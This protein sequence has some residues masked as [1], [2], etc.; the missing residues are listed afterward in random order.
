VN[1][2]LD[3]RQLRAFTV[4][5]RVASFTL[6]AK[7]LFLSQSAVSHSMKAL[8]QEVGC[9]LFD[10]VGKKVLL[11]Q[12][13]EQLLVYAERILADMEQARA[14]LK[15]LGQWGKGRVRIGASIMACQYILPQVLREFKESFPDCRI[16]IEPGDTPMAIE[17]LHANRIDLAIALQPLNEEKIEFDPLFT[18]ELAFLL[19]PMHPWA[20]SRRVIQDQIKHQNYILYSKNSYTMRIVEDYFRR[21]NVELNTVIELGSMEAIKEMVK[22][23]LGVGIVSPWIARDEIREGSLVCLRLGK[24]KL[25]RSWGIFH[26]KGRR[27]GLA[28]ETLAG[29][30]KSATETLTHDYSLKAITGA[31]L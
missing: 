22:L 6:A 2:P 24:R 23:G 1:Y 10:R 16:M 8:E 19:G 20:A 4:L 17:Y 11:T 21:E 12:A 15:E 18:D 25:R 27:L 26:L 14:S 28:E 30:C 3:S 5:A 13:G 29:L 9:R 7:E 31:D